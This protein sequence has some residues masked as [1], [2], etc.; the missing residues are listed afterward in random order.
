M[1]ALP[2]VFARAGFASGLFY[3]ILFA[4]VFI[5]VH[6]M[7]A[8]I[9]E[10]TPGRHRLVGYAN[11]YLKEPGFWVAVVTTGLGIV[12]ALTAYIIL[13]GKF[14]GLVVPQIG[15]S[16]T[17]YLFWVLGSLAIILSFRRLASLEFGITLAIGFIILVLFVM[18]FLR[19]GVVDIPLFDV[20]NLFLP[21]GIVLFALSGRAAISS[22][23][24]YYERNKL[25]KEKLHRSIVAGTVTPAI[26]YFV[27]ALAVFWLSGGNV[28]PDALSG[29][30]HLPV[31]VLALL[32]GLG[33]FAL[34]TSYFF[35][36]LEIKDIFRY[37]L[38]VPSP[39]AAFLVTVLP[40]G[41]YLVGF[42]NFIGLIGIA[43]G[44]FL[45][46]ESIVVISIYSRIRRWN[47]LAILLVALFGV[48]ALYALLQIF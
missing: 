23:S 43:G 8:D 39:L 25:S 31:P 34:W 48:G 32:S 46:I 21:Y 30:T 2:F 12:L 33:I 13:A 44:V 3:L 37:D 45:A 38:K 42:S 1:F 35:L 9:I 11:I 18:G 26:V 15:V 10:H 27:F 4:A 17:P 19:E 36:G 22:I 6:R 16:Y 28:S 29:L 7:Y 40:I 5:V 20:S 47:A 24:D 41:L 14:V